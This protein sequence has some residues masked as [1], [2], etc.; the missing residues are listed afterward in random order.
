MKSLLEGVGARGI[1]ARAVVVP[2]AFHAVLLGRIA[3]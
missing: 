2:T 1:L 3:R